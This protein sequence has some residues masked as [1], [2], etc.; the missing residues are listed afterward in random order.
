[1]LVKTY[2]NS[3]S[4]QME[5]VIL[6]SITTN[7]SALPKKITVKNF[8]Q[9]NALQLSQ[10]INH[11]INND[12][13]SVMLLE[14][15]DRVYK[16]YGLFSLNDKMMYGFFDE[17]VLSFEIEGK[18]YYGFFHG[19]YSYYLDCKSMS[20]RMSF[21]FC[22]YCIT[23]YSNYL[24]MV[25]DAIYFVPNGIIEVFDDINNYKGYEFQNMKECGGY[26]TEIDNLSAYQLPTLFV[27][28]KSNIDFINEDYNN[29]PDQLISN[30]ASVS[31]HFSTE[32]I[33]NLQVDS[34]YNKL[35]KYEEIGNLHCPVLNYQEVDKI[36]SGKV[37]QTCSN[38]SACVTPSYEVDFNTCILDNKDWNNF[39]SGVYVKY[40][41][42]VEISS[43]NVL[44]GNLQDEI[45]SAVLC[46]K[47]SVINAIAPLYDQALLLMEDLPSDI[48]F[49]TYLN[50]DAALKMDTSLSD[51]KLFYGVIKTFVE[52][53][54]NEDE[55][56]KL[57]TYYEANSIE[58]Q[59]SKFQQD[60]EN[61]I[62]EV[63]T[64]SELYDVFTYS[65]HFLWWTIN[66]DT[67]PFLTYDNTIKKQIPFIFNTLPGDMNDDSLN[68]EM[69]LSPFVM[70]SVDRKVS[71]INE[72]N[73]KIIDIL[74]LS[75]A[76]YNARFCGY[77]ND[78]LYNLKGFSRHTHHVDGIDDDTFKNLQLD[79]SYQKS[80]LFKFNAKIVKNPVNDLFDY[81]SSTYIK[82]VMLGYCEEQ[83]GE[84]NLS[85]DDLYSRL[86]SNNG[87]TMLF[88]KLEDY[89]GQNLLDFNFIKSLNG[90][91]ISNSDMSKTFQNGDNFSKDD[92]YSNEGWDFIS[93][94]LLD[95]Y[96]TSESLSISEALCLVI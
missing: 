28:E 37:Y 5:T 71:D 30:E 43:D 50:N 80:M 38:I 15:T 85:L 88:F 57:I 29:Y 63:L 22:S 59:L 12:L 58:G 27:G 41:T 74:T 69:C 52:F 17:S 79:G 49:L 67:L 93:L 3:I 92:E 91:E 32:G 35:L 70:E 36:T 33:N 9:F 46:S 45:D 6:Q 8:D 90:I 19:D 84:E 53:K 76:S 51:L 73:K 65:Q 66:R 68:I 55:W 16:F 40:T 86:F 60:C 78:S 7:S 87:E 75:L 20:S 72:T 47:Q 26:V 31:A 39:V 56:A 77:R 44:I 96:Q 95:S 61:S 4:Q 13:D 11:F 81:L 54:D 25:A 23:P 89:F 2:F 62:E 10:L 14:T 42:F 21:D 94:L 34:V 64:H 48:R 24:N 83:F 18:V 1:M 82:D